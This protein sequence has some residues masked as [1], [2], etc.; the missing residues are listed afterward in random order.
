MQIQVF[1]SMVQYCLS[2]EDVG[3]LLEQR[4][5]VLASTQDLRH[6]TRNF[7]NLAGDYMGEEI[8]ICLSMGSWPRH[9]DRFERQYDKAFARDPLFKADLMDRIHKRVHVFLHSC[10]TTAIKDVEL[11]GLAEFGG[12]HKKVERGEW[13]TLMPLWVD[14]PAQKEEGCRKS[15]RN[16]N[17]AR[18]S[19]GEGGCDAIFNHGIDPQLRIMERHGYMTGAA[20]FGEPP[21]PLGSGW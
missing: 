2:K 7:V 3:E 17:G 1:L 13:L 10:N 20:R 21:H 12:I 5:H 16:G 11:G 4:V 15:D 19:G 9:I 8:P 6:L 18:P 14:W